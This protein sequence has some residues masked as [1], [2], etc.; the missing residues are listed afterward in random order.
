M[1][2]K[3]LLL[4]LLLLKNP[5]AEE[6]AVKVAEKE[7]KEATETTEVIEETETSKRELQG[8]KERES[9]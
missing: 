5:V 8:E 1:E 4:H 7:V 9:N 3:T 2:R 6:E